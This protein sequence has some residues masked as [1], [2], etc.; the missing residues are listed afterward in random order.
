[1]C[2]TLLP[3]DIHLWKHFWHLVAAFWRVSFTLITFSS[4]LLTVLHPIYSYFNGGI[5]KRISWFFSFHHKNQL[6]VLRNLGNKLTSEKFRD[7]R[8]KSPAVT[9]V[10]DFKDLLVRPA[11]CWLDVRQEPRSCEQVDV[12]ILRG[13][14]RGTQADWGGRRGRGYTGKEISGEKQ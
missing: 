3:P 12:C 11:S 8:D 10:Q 6:F 1:M 5:F 4:I 14:E 2:I 13:T 7:E 9:V